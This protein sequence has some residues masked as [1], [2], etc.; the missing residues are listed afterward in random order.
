M[1]LNQGDT[2][3]EARRITALYVEHDRK[4]L[5]ELARV[6]KRGMDVADNEE[7]KSVAKE[8]RDL[9]TAAIQALKKDHQS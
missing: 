5:V 9:L 3:E 2:E 8:N 1:V 7:Y 6:W 4:N